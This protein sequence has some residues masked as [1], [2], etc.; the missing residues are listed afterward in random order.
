MNKNPFEDSRDYDR[1]E[2]LLAPG[3]DSPEAGDLAEE[4]A[5][6]TLLQDLGSEES[7][8]MPRSIEFRNNV[9]GKIQSHKR[10]RFQGLMAVA[11]VFLLGFVIY[12]VE[13]PGDHSERVVFDKEMLARAGKNQTRD[14]M[15]S[16]LENAERLLVSMRDFDEVSCSE[17]KTDLTPEKAMAR[18]LLLQQKLM[19]AEIDRPEFLQARQI[20][21]QLENIL[22]DLNGLDPCS[23]PLDVE[24]INEHISQK[25]IL[26]KL[27]LVASD[28]RIS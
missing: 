12:R 17:D 11:A 7:P 1:L 3:S 8:D 4:L 10:K 23:D 13:L 6:V 21:A 20:L 26:G 25:R 15:V 2:A 16:Y 19:A 18:T 14:A 9:M 22:I 27:R 28:I 24:L 5:L